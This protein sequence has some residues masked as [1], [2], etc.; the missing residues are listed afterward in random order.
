MALV[1]VRPFPHPVVSGRNLPTL[2]DVTLPGLSILSPSYLVPVQT[3]CFSAV[4]LFCFRR[5]RWIL[6][7]HKK[8]AF[9]SSKCMQGGGG[10]GFF[11]RDTHTH[12]HTH[13]H[14]K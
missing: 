14:T 9:G 10:G 6:N 13:T 1:C 8:N 11:Q 7:Y 2:A 12:T 4:A 5:C 3:Y